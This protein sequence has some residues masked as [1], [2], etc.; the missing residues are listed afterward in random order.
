MSTATPLSPADRLAHDAASHVTWRARERYL[1]DRAANGRIRTAGGLW[2]ADR[3]GHIVDIEVTVEYVSPV[4]PD[5]DVFLILRSLDGTGMALAMTDAS[6]RPDAL[7]WMDRSL[8]SLF[9]RATTLFGQPAIDLR[10]ATAIHG[11]VTAN[12]ASLPQAAVDA[13]RSVERTFVAEHD[14]AKEP[15]LPQHL[16][17]PHPQS[18]V[19]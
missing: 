18:A 10:R 9:A 11:S 17:G 14:K 19:R 1:A 6:E 2:L 5:G 12:T 7:S 16:R 8:V 4:S 15:T 3:A 13:M